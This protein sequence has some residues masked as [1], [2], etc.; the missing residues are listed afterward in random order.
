MKK[1][2][3]RTTKMIQNV[4]NIVA[5]KKNTPAGKVEDHRRNND[6]KDAC[7]KTICK[8]DNNQKREEDNRKKKKNRPGKRH[9]QEAKDDDD[10]TKDIAMV[11]DDCCGLLDKSI[12]N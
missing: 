2:R 3:L 8:N 5:Q 10:P 1:M 4:E 6:K 12:A 9:R 11:L 7:G